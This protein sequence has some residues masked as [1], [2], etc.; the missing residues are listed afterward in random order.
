MSNRKIQWDSKNFAELCSFKKMRNKF[1][2]NLKLVD[3]QL[4]LVNL[5]FKIS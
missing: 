5:K 4:K 1:S 2:Y 3:L